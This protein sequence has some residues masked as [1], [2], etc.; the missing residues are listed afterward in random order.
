VK[1]HGGR[2]RTVH[3]ETEDSGI[4][5]Q[6]VKNFVEGS[7]PVDDLV[8]IGIGLASGSWLAVGAGLVSLAGNAWSFL[9]DPIAG[10]ASWVVSWL[11]EHVS[12]LDDWFNKFTGD[13]E[14]VA[15]ASYNWQ[16]IAASLEF[17]AND[18]EASL[19]TALADQT[20]VALEAYK[21]FIAAEAE[22]LKKVGEAAANV[23]SA[24]QLASQLVQFV[25]NTV[26]DAISDVIGKFASAAAY[27]LFFP[28]GAP[29]LLADVY[30]LVCKWVTKV[31]KNIEAAIQ[32][33]RALNEQFDKLCKCIEALAALFKKLTKPFKTL[34]DKID[35][36][37]ESAGKKFGEWLTGSG[38]SSFDSMGFMSGTPMYPGTGSPV[39]DP[40]AVKTPSDWRPP[41]DQMVP[42]YTQPVAPAVD[43]TIQVEKIGPKTAFNHSGNEPNTMYEITRKY[44]ADTTY[45]TKLYTDANGDVTFIETSFGGNNYRNPDLASVHPNTTFVVEGAGENITYISNEAGRTTISQIPDYEPAPGLRSESIQ[46]KVGDLGGDGYDGGHLMANR[47]GAGGESQGTVP[48]LAETN[49][50]FAD[51]PERYRGQFYEMEEYFVAERARRLAID[52]NAEFP[53]AI[54]AV[55]GAD[56][57]VPQGFELRWLDENGEIEIM[58]L[59]NTPYV[60]ARTMVQSAGEI[61]DGASSVSSL[62]LEDVRALAESLGASPIS[63]ES[64]QTLIQPDG[65]SGGN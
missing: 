4:T 19:T 63:P 8:S 3:S 38:T 31:S 36:A 52:P 47:V 53:V 40:D 35:D 51:L 2:A 17:V 41:Q 43:Q 55:Y 25:H 57:V 12:P 26:R 45:T 14:R 11:L 50:N 49:R 58:V 22:D 15:E 9:K 65:G 62:S 30:D 42:P 33:F 24:L 7:G 10:V 48:M 34:S 56:K 61:V 27:V 32:S 39:V 46:G 54:E 16:V 37:A 21:A 5:I 20:S 64:G 28:P 59:D 13:H 44:D 23:G 18:L 6:D 29:K 60:D 1:F